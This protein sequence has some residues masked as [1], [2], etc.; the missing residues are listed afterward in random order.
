[1]KFKKF[2]MRI[3]KT[4]RRINRS[5]RPETKRLLLVA[6][7]AVVAGCFLG[8]NI[9]GKREKKKAAEALKKQEE[10][11]KSE[12]QGK[13][14]ELQGKLDEALSTEVVE[15]PWNLALV[16]KNHPM[17]H[18]YDLELTELEP[19]Y[20]VDSRIAEAAKKM[21]AD[22]K[23]AGMRIVI[24]SAYRSVVRQEQVFNDSVQERL[25]RGMDYW[26]AFADTRLS[27]AE[28]GTSEHA[29]GLALDLVSN[30]YTELDERQE[31]TKEARW[32]AENCSKYGFI[33]R[34]PPS[35]TEITG[36]IYEP[37]HYRYVGVEDA[38]KIMNL[39]VTLEEYLEEYY[40][41]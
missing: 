17:D 3:G 32:L 18:D 30:Q 36:I 8:G 29:M 13:V 37:W 38:E 4:L 35:K 22:A 25:N 14:D 6:L 20:S 26:D 24:C 31:T 41:K 10:Q 21:L 40:K 39:G 28:P 23:A 34:Y 2:M 19:G 15:L 16:N 12:G 27:V 5:M 1:M 11:L 9:V 7:V 33:L